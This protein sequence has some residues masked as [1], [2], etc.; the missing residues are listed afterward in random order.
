MTDSN[1]N[2]G[3]EKN[4]PFGFNFS[5]NG[6]S[7][8]SGG[9]EGKGGIGGIFG[10]L[11]NLLKTVQELAEKGEELQKSGALDQDGKSV[12]YGF[13][14]KTASGGSS[15]GTPSYKVEPFGNVTTD[16]KGHA[17]VSETREP[18]TDVFDDEQAI[19]VI[20]EMPGIAE[21]DITLTLNGDVLELTAQ[22]GDKSFAKTVL[23]PAVVSGEPTL[24][25]NNGV[26][27]ITLRKA[28]GSN[29]SDAA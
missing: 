25:C 18:P 24:T 23:L 8:E 28:A 22:S 4:G 27:T 7:A 14:I 20:A 5:I 11:N 1:N 17:T 12:H 13:S 6:N 19:T 9:G 15:D 3:S 10:G 21:S 2:Q 29:E 26:A 16:D